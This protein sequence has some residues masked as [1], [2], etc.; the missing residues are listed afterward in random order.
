MARKQFEITVTGSY[1]K[2]PIEAIKD[3]LRYDSGMVQSMR[4]ADRKL[5][6]HIISEQYT[7]ARW[8]SFGFKTSQ[9]NI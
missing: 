7:P 4:A 5:T 2:E 1:F 6:A 8:A 9:R 3:M